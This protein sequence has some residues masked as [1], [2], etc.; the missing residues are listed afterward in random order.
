MSP[1]A[2][3]FYQHPSY[4][5]AKSYIQYALH[6]Q[7]GLVVVAGKPG[8][9][10]TTL[11]NQLYQELKD[12]RVEI[13]KLSCNAMNS[14]ELLRHYVMKLTDCNSAMSN[15]ELLEQL[16]KH[17]TS[18]ATGKSI[19]VLILDEAQALSV[20]ALEEVRLLTNLEMDNKPLLQV[21]IFGHSELLET[22]LKPELEQL[23]QRIV[24]ACRLDTLDIEQTKAYWLHRLKSVG[25]TVDPSFEDELY[26]MIHSAS[27]GIPRWINLIGTRL[28][29]MGMVD[30][31][32]MFT[33]NHLR[34]VVMELI[35]EDLL[36]VGVRYRARAV[37]E[38]KT[39][40]ESSEPGSS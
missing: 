33:K 7:E 30:G 35:D 3:S 1:D 10:K 34:S 19:P 24:A 28:L 36:P 38:R 39:N 40:S 27:L 20:Q 14:G 17:L 37:K 5:K 13:T 2:E 12:S 26:P 18:A 9:G 16:E 11:I 8:T 6:K 22:I 4:K 29:L 15:Y 21:F 23:H 32:H 25:W 31:I